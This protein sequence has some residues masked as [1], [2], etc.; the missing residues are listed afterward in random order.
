MVSTTD[1]W[2]RQRKYGSPGCW[3]CCENGGF[4]LRK[5]CACLCV[6][7]AKN[8][9]DD[10]TYWKITVRRETSS[11]LDIEKK[12]VSLDYGVVHFKWSHSDMVRQLKRP[13]LSGSSGCSRA[14][15]A[16]QCSFL[17]R[18]VLS[19]GFNVVL[20]WDKLYGFKVLGIFSSIHNFM[21]TPSFVNAD[22]LVTKWRTARWPIT[23]WLAMLK[24]ELS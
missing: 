4:T 6:C 11:S 7:F 8:S 14:P 21:L 17:F 16:Q 10:R 22:L 1:R 9:F 20:R 3:L 13:T 2:R 12:K 24:S 5:V 23:H 19:L 15:R 18:T